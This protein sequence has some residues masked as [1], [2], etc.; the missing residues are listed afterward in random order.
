M[1][2]PYLKPLSCNLSD[3]RCSFFNTS[4]S[5]RWPSTLMRM[6]FPSQIFTIAGC[7]CDHLQR[8]RPSFWLISHFLLLDLFRGSLLESLWGSAH[9]LPP[10]DTVGPASAQYAVTNTEII[11]DHC[12]NSTGGVL[13]TLCDVFNHTFGLL[14]DGSSVWSILSLPPTIN[15]GLT[16]RWLRKC[17]PENDDEPISFVV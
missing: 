17:V 16:T 8:S 1:F 3:K 7:H 6:P 11:A 4:K 14:D 15:G 12:C 10:L 5:Y 9:H 2:P 13:L